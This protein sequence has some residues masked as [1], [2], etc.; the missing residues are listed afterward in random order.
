MSSDLVQYTAEIVEA[1]LS[2][3]EIPA[4]EVPSLLSDVFDTLSRLKEGTPTSPENTIKS[5]KSQ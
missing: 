3:H 5:A 2:N 1:Y 4:K